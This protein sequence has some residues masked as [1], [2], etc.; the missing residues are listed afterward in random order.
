MMTLKKKILNKI[1]NNLQW[2]SNSYEWHSEC[3][4]QAVSFRRLLGLAF[5][6]HVSRSM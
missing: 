6:W 4:M 3:S 5:Y 1:L 2:R